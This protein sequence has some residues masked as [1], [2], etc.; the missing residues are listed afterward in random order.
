MIAEE[1]HLMRQGELG[2]LGL[3]LDADWKCG[4][5]SV[6]VLKMYGRA[7]EGESCHATGPVR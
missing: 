1:V 4:S 3:G 2:G 6:G 7:K 5:W